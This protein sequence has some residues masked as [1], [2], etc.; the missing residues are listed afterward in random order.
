MSQINLATPQTSLIG[1]KDQKAQVATT[2]FFNEDYLWRNAGLGELGLLPNGSFTAGCTGVAGLVSSSVGTNGLMRISTGLT[3]GGGQ[4]AAANCGYAST[5]RPILLSTTQRLIYQT[6]VAAV[7]SPW[8]LLA[9]ATSYLFFGIDDVASVTSSHANAIGFK[10]DTNS[11]QGDRIVAS[12]ITRSSSVETRTNPSNSFFI[13][14]S[15]TPPVFRT[16]MFDMF[17][18]SGAW[19]VNFYKYWET[20]SSVGA[21]GQWILLA[22]HTTNIPSAL[23]LAPNFHDITLTS[24]AGSAGLRDTDQDYQTIRIIN[25]VKRL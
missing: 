14:T 22:T 7:S 23:A 12:P 2:V 21:A 8:P 24:S 13:K 16:F 3:G 18:E 6:R 4:N 20:G 11:F 15:D 19:K 10:V 9:G 17:Y 1:F 5:T 25:S